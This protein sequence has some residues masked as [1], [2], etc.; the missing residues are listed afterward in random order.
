MKKLLLCM[1]LVL[2]G[3]LASG[4]TLYFGPED[5]DDDRYY[6]Y[7]DQSGCWT[8]DSET[9]ECWQDGGGWGCYSNSDCAAGCWCDTNSGTCVETGF[10]SYNEEC[11]DGYVCDDRQSCVPEQPQA[12]WEAGCPW[13]YYCDGWSGECIPSTTCNSDAECGTGYA[14][15][16]GTCTPVGCTDDTQCAAGCYCDEA[17]GGCVESGYCS[18]DGDC[19][20]GQTCDEARGTC[21]PSDDPPPP[22]PPPGCTEV[23]DEMTCLGRAECDAVYTGL[24][25]T[26]PNN[27]QA[28]QSGDSGCV[29]EDFVFAACI[30]A[31]APAN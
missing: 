19:P 15:L 31:V 16:D 26:N 28:C 5:G 4:C 17:S 13:G 10:C 2:A 18:A 25:C 23:F 1:S 3:S 14:C 9:G 24:N 6:S 12:C 8:C 7:C 22:P 20:S 29:C 21:I 11:P 27:G 30:D